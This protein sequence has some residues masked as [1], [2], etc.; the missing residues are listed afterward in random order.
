MKRETFMKASQQHAMEIISKMG[1]RA[2]L[3]VQLQKGV[4]MQL[5]YKLLTKKKHVFLSLP[6]NNIYFEKCAMT[7]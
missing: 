6:S 5:V 1:H 2:G 3:S 7:L 4:C